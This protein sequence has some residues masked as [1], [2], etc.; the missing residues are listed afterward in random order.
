MENFIKTTKMILN[1]P[2]KLDILYDN[3]ED[4]NLIE[5]G[6]E[7]DVKTTLKKVIFYSID[8]LRPIDFGNIKNNNACIS[9]GGTDYI[10]N[11][12]MEDVEKLIEL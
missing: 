2:L 12:S 5:M 11:L 6:V 7:V 9:S 4:L 3:R 1:K 10:C 8:T